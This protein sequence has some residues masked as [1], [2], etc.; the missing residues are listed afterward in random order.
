MCSEQLI[1]QGA[2]RFRAGVDAKFISNQFRI[3]A[4]RFCFLGEMRAGFADKKPTR[5]GESR[6]PCYIYC[7]A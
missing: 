6:S 4:L 3:E 1:F 5:K 7:V 2:E